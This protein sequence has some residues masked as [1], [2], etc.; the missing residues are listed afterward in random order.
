MPFLCDLIGFASLIL[1]AWWVRKV[2]TATLVGF[3]ATI[4]NFVFRPDAYHF[5]GFTAASIVF[6]ILTF[7]IGYKR[8][9][10]KNLLGSISLFII[11]VFSAAVAGLIIGAFFLAPSILQRWG[12]I[13]VWAGLHAVGGVIGGSVGV[14]IINALAIRGITTEGVKVE[15]AKKIE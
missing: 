11:S 3:I 14:S 9:F 2:G 12:G 1:A 6:D 7:L 8:L 4:T 10:E 13:L 15:E 5:F